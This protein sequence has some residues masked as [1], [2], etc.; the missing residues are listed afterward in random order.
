MPLDEA[1]SRQ[2]KRV[3]IKVFVPGL[4]GS[5]IEELKA[6]LAKHPGDCPLYFDLETP[7]AHRVVLQSGEVSGIDLSEPLTRQIQAL[8][9]ENAVYIEY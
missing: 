1:F 7:H 3:V 6:L 5:V 8:L 2:A 9:G 4:E